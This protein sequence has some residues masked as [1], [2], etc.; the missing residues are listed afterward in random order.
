MPKS[1]DSII[2][3]FEMARAMVN[4]GTLSRDEEDENEKRHVPCAQ[5]GVWVPTDQ[6][7]DQGYCF[8]CVYKK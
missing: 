8:L 3:L 2:D 6:I 1:N 7:D 5:C 4:D